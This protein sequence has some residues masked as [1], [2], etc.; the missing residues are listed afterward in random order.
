MIT[1][2]SLCQLLTLINLAGTGIR[3]AEDVAEMYTMWSPLT[4]NVVPLAVDRRM[5]WVVASTS[6]CGMWLTGVHTRRRPSSPAACAGSDD[7]LGSEQ[8]LHSVTSGD[9]ARAQVSGALLRNPG[10]QFGWGEAAG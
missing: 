6:R 5:K 1:G 2:S 10:C 7:Q 3:S 9:T 8:A 4:V